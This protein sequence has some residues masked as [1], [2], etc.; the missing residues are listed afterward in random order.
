MGRREPGTEGLFV[1]ASSTRVSF[2]RMPRFPWG[3][4]HPRGLAATEQEVHDAWMRSP[5]SR[6]IGTGVTG[7]DHHEQAHRWPARSACRRHHLAAVTGADAPMPPAAR[8]RPGQLCIA[9]ALG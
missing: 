3:G 9:L 2:F 6:C 5:T 8:L 7:R 1:V 4:T